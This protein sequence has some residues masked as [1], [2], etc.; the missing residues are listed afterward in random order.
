[1]LVFFLLLDALTTDTP[2]STVMATQRGAPQVIYHEEV[3][4][5]DDNKEV[6]D[7]EEEPSEAENK[8]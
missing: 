4:K 8:D 2:Q 7:T 6:H 1:M 5:N 3:V